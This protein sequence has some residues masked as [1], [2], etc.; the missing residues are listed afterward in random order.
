MRLLFASALVLTLSTPALAAAGKLETQGD[1]PI[2]VPVSAIEVSI[3][4]EIINDRPSTFEIRRSRA[5]NPWP[6]SSREAD[7]LTQ[8]L[9]R[10]LLSDLGDGGLYAPEA[11]ADGATLKVEIEKVSPSQLNFTDAGFRAG[12]R[13]GSWSVGG[14]TLNA[15]LVDAD[16]NELRSY[17]YRNYD[18]PWDARNAIG[19]YDEAERTLRRFSD[20]VTDD[21]ETSGAAV[22]N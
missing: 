6:V 8:R 16:G 21:I 13:A 17:S 2:E 22:P 15:T 3:N 19:S 11:G 14:A 9:E 4:P 1:A 12:Y 5:R 7:K 20:K 10:E 18:T